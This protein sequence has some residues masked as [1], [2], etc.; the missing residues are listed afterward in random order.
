M[1]VVLGQKG[2]FAG[3][4]VEERGKVFAWPAGAWTQEYPSQ[5]LVPCLVAKPDH[6]SP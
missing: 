6:S 1:F 3:R 4:W 5:V 2:Q